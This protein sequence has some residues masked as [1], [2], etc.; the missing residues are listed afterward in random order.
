MSPA[1]TSAHTSAS[2]ATSRLQVGLHLSSEEHD[3]RSLVET[4]AMA[5]R[6]GF[7]SKD[8]VAQII[9]L[10]AAV[11]AVVVLAAAVAAWF[12]LPSSHV[13]PTPGG[14]THGTAAD[15]DLSAAG[16][17]VDDGKMEPAPLVD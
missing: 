5:E 14:P 16:E 3:A 12:L 4:A 2:T 17:V 8:N 10:A 13:A 15:A 6:L 9:G 1:P 7:G 11:A